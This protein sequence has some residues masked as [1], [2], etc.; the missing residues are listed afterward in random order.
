MITKN[1]MNIWYKKTLTTHFTQDI[2]NIILKLVNEI[3]NKWEVLK[4]NILQKYKINTFHTL[5]YFRRPPEKICISNAN[6]T[7]YYYNLFWQNNYKFVCKITSIQIL[8]I[9]PIIW[10]WDENDPLDDLWFWD[11][12]EYELEPD[13]DSDSQSEPIIQNNYI[14]YIQS[15]IHNN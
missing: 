9:N 10:Y 1:E 2:S 12:V 8:F 5:L 15:I 13:S 11:N 4:S 6:N 14:N 7:Y 3:S